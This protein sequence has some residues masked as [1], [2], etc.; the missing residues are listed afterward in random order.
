MIDLHTHTTMSDG[1]LSPEQLVE[2][3]K[4][5]GLSA[6]GIADHDSVEGVAAAQ[7]ASKECALEIVPCMELSCY[8]LER[9]R[10]EFHLLGYYCNQQNGELIERLEFF[11][12]ERLRRAQKS[13]KLLN[14]LG[15][16]GDWDYLIKM[17]VGTVG[18]PHLARTVLENPQNREKLV[19]EFGQ[20]PHLG[21]FIEKYLIFGQSAY[22]EKAG[23]EPD[24]AI[25]L[26]HQA[27]GVAILAHPCFD[28][29]MEVEDTLKIFKEWEL[30]GLEAIAP[31]KNPPETK[32]KI[33]FFLK[34]AR[35]FNF[36]VTGG[37]D[38]HGLDGVGAG[39][40]LLEWGLSID[41]QY[42]VDLKTCLESKR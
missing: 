23:F 20:L 1:V 40:G 19:K 11:R 7:A 34:M 29:E 9:N 6:L 27:G 4:E 21:Q 18:R 24:K 41:D 33:D 15:Y 8:W 36:L 38:Y 5:K 35:K 31:Y 25:K 39:L 10:K 37:S 16:F 3:A 13:L 26:I 28:L 42:L 14:D 32:I 12:Q 2:K 30:D 22:V 17:A